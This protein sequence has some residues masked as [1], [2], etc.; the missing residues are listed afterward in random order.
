MCGTN[1]KKTFDGPER[2]ARIEKLK[3]VYDIL[4][5]KAVPNVDRIAV[6]YA[7]DVHGAVA[8]LEPKG[9]SVVP[10]SIQQV[11]EA[12]GCILEAL[13]VSLLGTVGPNT[14]I[15]FFVGYAR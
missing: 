8:F 7:D 4:R 12:V 14:L 11:L 13:T 6:S 15:I 9:L 3:S 10:K 5:V 2:H 1:I